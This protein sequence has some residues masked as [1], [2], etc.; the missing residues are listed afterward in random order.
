V[1]ISDLRA[2]QAQADDFKHFDYVI[3]MDDCNHN[4]LSALCPC[5]QNSDQRK[6]L[7]LFMDFAP[8]LGQSEVPDPYYGD[9]DG[10]ETVLDMIETASAGLL[11]DIRKT[12]L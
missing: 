3:A 1:D 12:H 8:E 11:A 5:D 6:R 9:D 4:D 7:H 2:R 10:F